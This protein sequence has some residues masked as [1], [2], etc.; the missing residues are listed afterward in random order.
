MLAHPW[1]TT[2]TLS[3][4]ENNN[5]LLAGTPS[6]WADGS[7]RQLNLRTA[8]PQVP[9]VFDNLPVLQAVQSL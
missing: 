4:E 2:A 6:A 8:A 5:L 9:T 1:L 7:L 3:Q